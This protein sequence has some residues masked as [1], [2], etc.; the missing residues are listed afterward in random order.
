M[1]G[2]TFAGNLRIAPVD[3]NGVVQG[4]GYMGLL[5]AVKCALK[6]PAA[7]NIDQISRKIGSVGQ[8]ISRAQIPKATELEVTVDDTD[9]QRMLA[10]AL[11]GI[12]ANY[13]QSGVTITDEAVTCGALN[14]W[15]P[16]A[17]RK[18]SSVVVTNT[19]ATTTYVAGTDYLVD[20]EAGFICPLSSGAITANQALKVDYVAAALTGKTVQIATVASTLLR[21]HVQLQ[22]LVDGSVS[23]F[24]API[25][26]ATAS[27]DQDFFGK[28]MLVAG[29]SGAMFLPPVGTAAYTET[30]GAASIFTALS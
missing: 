28:N 21:V 26:Q 9:D 8:I 20:A 15:V 10:Y 29:L 18:V 30:G 11:N 27:G 1:S 5:N 14:D 22:S 23:Y 2:R 24:I 25:Y 19:G 16:L 3:K 12:V 7:E 6:V 13:S 17:N 4:H